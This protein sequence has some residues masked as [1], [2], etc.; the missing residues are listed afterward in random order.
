[1]RSTIA[2]YSILEHSLNDTRVIYCKYYLC[3]MVVEKNQ[4]KYRM[5]QVSAT[6]Y[7]KLM[8][9]KHK[10]EKESSSSWSF[11]DVIERIIDSKDSW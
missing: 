4:K 8:K 1:M 2:T 10:L 5:V 11:S 7:E 6:T 9:Q 3:F